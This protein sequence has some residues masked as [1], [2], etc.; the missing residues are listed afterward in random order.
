MKEL[1]KYLVKRREIR[2]TSKQINLQKELN[3]NLQKCIDLHR[4]LQLLQEERGL[5]E[6][7]LKISKDS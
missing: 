3:Y 5:L 7:K 4:E 6:K 1:I 2:L